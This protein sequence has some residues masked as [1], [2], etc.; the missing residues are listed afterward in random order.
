M[1]V[2]SQ[3]TRGQESSFHCSIKMSNNMCAGNLRES[4]WV[5]T[6]CPVR[7]PLQVRAACSALRAAHVRVS[8][9]AAARHVAFHLAVT[10]CK[11]SEQ[12]VSAVAGANMKNPS[13]AVLLQRERR[14]LLVVFFFFYAA[15]IF[16]FFF[17]FFALAG[18]LSRLLGRVSAPWTRTER[19]D[20]GYRLRAEVR[21]FE[22]KD[23]C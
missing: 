17:L 18:L 4:E 15:P 2:L 14:L 10:A 3:Q 1:A 21:S 16:F 9:S 13:K 5:L 6:G 19:V 7:T 11:C 20:S 12:A 8:P 23:G 22:C